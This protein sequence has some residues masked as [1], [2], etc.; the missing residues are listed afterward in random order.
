MATHWSLLAW[1]IPW[2]EGPGGL[3]S[4]GWQRVRHN[5]GLN[6][7]PAK[8]TYIQYF[9]SHSNLRDRHFQCIQMKKLRLREMSDPSRVTLPAS[10]W[11]RI[12]SQFVWLQTPCHNQLTICPPRNP[13]LNAVHF[14][15][16]LSFFFWLCHMACVM[17]VLWP[18]IKLVPLQW[19]RRV[20]SLNH[21]RSP[22]GCIL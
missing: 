19:K 13:A 3:Q 15:D 4:M 1:E 2:T 17:L 5:L 20:P 7:N 10:N 16:F 21:Q 18:G 12:Q 6:N 8:V 22:N 9:T 14:V 11:G